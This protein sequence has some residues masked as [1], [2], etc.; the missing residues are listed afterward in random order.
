MGSRKAPK[1]HS[2]D[3]A[4][5]GYALSTSI[6]NPLYVYMYI[7]GQRLM[8]F[9]FV[10]FHRKIFVGG[11]AKETNLGEFSMGFSSFLCFFVVAGS[12]QFY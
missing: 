7:N 9:F 10:V 12:V 1:T 6:S 8:G 5:P 4:S 3:G 2:D 11:L